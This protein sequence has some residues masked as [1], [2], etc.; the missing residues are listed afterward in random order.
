MIKALHPPVRGF[1]FVWPPRA[2]PS[3]SLCG[4][5]GYFLHLM[6]LL[7]VSCGA[8]RCSL[9]LAAYFVVPCGAKRVSLH[10]A[11]YFVVPFGAKRVSLHLAML[12]GLSCGAN[13]CPLHRSG[14]MMKLFFVVNQIF[15]IFTETSHGVI[16]TEDD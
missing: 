8:N 5:K 2:A 3:T 15:T 14:K 12:F 7:G 1:L 16:E 13:R 11:T 10:L 6:V 9:H 4:A